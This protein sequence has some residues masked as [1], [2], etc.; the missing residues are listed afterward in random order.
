MNSLPDRVGNAT[1]SHGSQ[2]RWRAAGT[3]F[4]AGCQR[5]IGYGPAI[6][7][8]G[9]LSAWR[10]DRSAASPSRNGSSMVLF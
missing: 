6:F 10:R 8:R 5:R 7:R 9:A 4:S 2:R 3:T 1:A